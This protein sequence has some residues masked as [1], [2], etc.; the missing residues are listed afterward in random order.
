MH[1]GGRTRA[2]VSIYSGIVGSIHS[3]RNH[4]GTSIYVCFELA[5]SKALEE[6]IIEAKDEQKSSNRGEKAA[7]CELL[8]LHPRTLTTCAHT[9]AKIRR[10]IFMDPLEHIC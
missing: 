10:P 1:W 4:I 2:N 5:R 3:S 7:E 9:H 6:T 8:Q